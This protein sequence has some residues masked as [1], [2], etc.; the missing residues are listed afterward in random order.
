MIE[1]SLLT[2]CP[3]TIE[4]QGYIATI[5]GRSTLLLDTPGFD[6]TDRSDFEIVNEVAMGLHV[7]YEQGLTLRGVIYIQ[8]ITDTR[9]SGSSRK[10]LEIL[11]AI[12][13]TQAS[14]NITFV[15]TMWDKLGVDSEIVGGERTEE[16]KRLFLSRFIERGANVERH[17]GTAASAKDIVNKMILYD[18]PIILSIQSEMEE[19]NLTLDQTKVGR[20]LQHDL[21]QKQKEF[22]AELKEM[23]QQL[24]EAQQFNDRTAIEMLTE[25]LA[26][27][28][29]QILRIQMSRS[30]LASGVQQLWDIKNA[31]IERELEE[32]QK[33]ELA[34][35]QDINNDIKARIQRTNQRTRTLQDDQQWEAHKFY[36]EKARIQNGRNQQHGERL[37][38]QK[39]RLHAERQRRRREATRA[40][41]STW[42]I[43]VREV[44]VFQRRSRRY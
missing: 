41:M 17:T 25:D 14:A 13:G 2:Y 18:Q 31:N 1:C 44:Y 16:M 40:T 15:T 30:Q 11:D 7:L 24:L 5:D 8:R 23:E 32:A 43:C 19:Q 26:R 12:C 21:Q 20:I 39:A 35:G 10:S 37:T 27:Q 9:M 3:G 33:L 38:A 28:K 22:D 34:L 4:A 6:D 29:E 36:E 42:E